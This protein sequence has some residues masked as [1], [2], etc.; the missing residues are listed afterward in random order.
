MIEEYVIDSCSD[1][2]DVTELFLNARGWEGMRI[3][4]KLNKYT[5]C[6]RHALG[7]IQ[8]VTFLGKILLELSHVNLFIYYLHFH[9]TNADLNTYDR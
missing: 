4:G 2:T 5:H 1:N 3:Y 7:Q 8:F 6:Y 9:A